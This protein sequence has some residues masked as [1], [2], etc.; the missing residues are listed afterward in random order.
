[1]FQTMRAVTP[2]AALRDAIFRSGMSQR[3]VAKLAGMPESYLSQIVRGRMNPT[4]TQIDAIAAALGQSA[5]AL[6]AQEVA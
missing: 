1:M 3:E 4:D 5:D 2:R 6:F